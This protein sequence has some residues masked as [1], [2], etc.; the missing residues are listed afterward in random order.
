MEVRIYENAGRAGSRE[1]GAGSREQGAENLWR[2]LFLVNDIV[3]D[4]WDPARLRLAASA[5]EEITARWQAD[6]DPIG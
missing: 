1:Q 4:P 5:I 2:M 6:D 3:R